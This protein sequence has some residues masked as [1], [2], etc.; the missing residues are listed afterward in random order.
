MS[1]KLKLRFVLRHQHKYRWYWRHFL[2]CHKLNLPAMLVEGSKDW[3]L[4]TRRLALA[5]GANVACVKRRSPV[6]AMLS[7]ATCSLASL[8]LN[9]TNWDNNNNINYNNK[10]QNR[11]TAKEA[12]RFELGESR[13]EQFAHCVDATAAAAAAVAASELESTHTVRRAT[14]HQSNSPN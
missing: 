9:E 11:H 3:P 12:A 4:S 8:E 5:T 6:G 1:C 2:I 10:Q 7:A 13:G 14:W